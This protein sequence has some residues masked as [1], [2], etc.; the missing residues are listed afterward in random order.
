MTRVFLDDRSIRGDVAMVRGGDCHHLLSVLRLGV[1]DSFV[2]VD[3]SGA[4]RVASITGIRGAVIMASLGPP[5]QRE[6]EPPVGI[7]LYQG[8]PRLSRYEA[9]LRM[10]TE[11]GVVEFAP[12]LSGKSV[13]RLG[14]ADALRKVERWERVVESAARQSGRTTVPLVL[15]PMTFEMALSH[16]AAS[17][18][19]GIMPVAGLAGSDACSLGEV[20]ADLAASS[21]VKELAL[22]IGPEAGFDLGEQAA[23]EAAGI[24]LVTMGPRILRTETAAVVAATVC[25]ERFAALR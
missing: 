17:G 6:T 15:E 4:E 22:F 8:L 9:S 2:V 1:G 3:S 12:I 5:T 13:V 24:A 18:D 14:E 21:D 7:V 20:A 25:L 10:C 19:P 11:L 16:Y 23:A